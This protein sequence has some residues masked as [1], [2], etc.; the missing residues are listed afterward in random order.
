L[1]EHHHHHHHTKRVVRVRANLELLEGDVHG[2]AGV[3][4][5]VVETAEDADGLLDQE[6]VPEPAPG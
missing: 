3:E 5:Q 1:C 2:H 4:Y 6:P